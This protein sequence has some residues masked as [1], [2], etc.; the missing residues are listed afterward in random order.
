MPR[1]LHKDEWYPLVPSP[2][3]ERVRGGGNVESPP[4]RP[5][6]LSEQARDG[7]QASSSP[8]R[9]RRFFLKI[10]EALTFGR[11]DL[12]SIVRP[13]FAIDLRRNIFEPWWPL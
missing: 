3:G 8:S 13:Y 1:A 9:G 4:S 12:L 5:P 7:G 6:R 11:S 2:L 10:F